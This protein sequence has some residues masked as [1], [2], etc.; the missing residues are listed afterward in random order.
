[1]NQ[2]VVNEVD[3]DSL[4]H[5]YQEILNIIDIPVL[6]FDRYT[7]QLAFANRHA[8]SFF[9]EN[10]FNHKSAHLNK[11]IT[12]FD[13]STLE[14]IRLS[15]IATNGSES[16]QFHCHA[17]LKILGE[18]PFPASIQIK[19]L[20][21][22]SQYGLFIFRDI[23]QDRHLVNRLHFHRNHDALTGLQKRDYFEN[24]VKETIESL[25]ENPQ[26]K[27]ACHIKISHLKIIND[28]CGSAAGDELIRELTEC[29]RFILNENDVFCRISGTE[30]GVIFLD[31]KVDEGI[32]KIKELLDQMLE[33]EFEWND[34]PMPVSI[35]AGLHVLEDSKEDWIDA[36][37]YMDA[38]CLSSQKESENSFKLFKQSD[39]A[40]KAKHQQM[41]LVSTIIKAIQNNRFQLY[42]QMIVPLKEDDCKPHVEIL[43]R[44]LN[45]KGEIVSP[46]H[47]LPAAESYNLIFMIDKWVVNKTLKWFKENAEI[48]S[49][50]FI[51]NINLSGFSIGQRGFAEALIYAIRKN[52]IPPGQV[53]FEIT[54]TAAIKDF[55]K[56]SK[57][58]KVMKDFGCLFALDDFGSGMS[59]FGYLKNLEADII[60]I[61]GSL[62][63]NIHN[64]KIDEV[65]VR[66]IHDIAHTMGLQTVAEFVENEE[67]LT[68]LKDIGIDYAQGYHFSKPQQLQQLTSELN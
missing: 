46:V 14:Q 44:L 65:M 36:I 21:S 1:M 16:H 18:E 17:L 39:S 54:E 24:A 48:L 63:K 3:F 58:M 7:L 2:L 37:S 43:I 50:G 9:P 27:L 29:I 25:N 19:N 68:V 4:N 8:I 55:E 40:V 15:P 30:F 56:A 35:N 34:K 22:N 23:S 41:G 10:Y 59:S 49:R 38:A 67:I 57:F 52:N 12:I 45:D 5:I 31:S 64:D 47:F 53:C 33:F 32:D 28:V 13:E 26:P 11:V 60:K 66:S 42:Y 6:M 51:C 62:V 20:N 61:D